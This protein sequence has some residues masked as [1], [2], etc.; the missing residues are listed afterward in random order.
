VI[1]EEPKERVFWEPLAA[2]PPEVRERR[3]AGILF[4]VFVLK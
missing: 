4:V 1:L 3:V 2:G